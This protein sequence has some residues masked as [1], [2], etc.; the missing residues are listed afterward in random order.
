M[1]DA[2]SQSRGSDSPSRMLLRTV[3]IWSALATLAI[4]ILGGGLGLLVAGQNGLVS[5]LLGSA[6]AF[7]F[8][9]ITVLSVVFGSRFSLA[10]FYGLVLGG[11]LLKVIVFGAV[12][13]VLRTA[14]FVHGPTF[15]FALV[16]AVIAGLGIDSWVALRARIP[17]TDK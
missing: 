1:A 2:V 13:V 10:G 12:L 15:F 9:L 16:A 17:I 11:W 8:S 4:A 5:A 3:V 14:E 7:A 6:I